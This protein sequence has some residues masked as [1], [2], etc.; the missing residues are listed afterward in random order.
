M[1]EGTSAVK[2]E[3]VL[4]PKF[5]SHGTLGSKDLEASRKFY[6]QFLGIEVIRTSKISMMIRLGGEHV[7]AVVEQKSR[8]EVM[9]RINHNGLDVGTDAEVDE[10]HRQCTEQAEKWGIHDITKPVVQHGTYSFM[11]W[12]L[13]DNCWEILSNPR[14]GYTWIFEQ[15][16]LSGKGHWEKDFRSKRPDMKSEK[17][18]S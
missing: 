11:F 1:A 16:D 14:G 10:A 13:D 8:K 5:I 18:A 4:K 17:P 9:Q 15:G 3:S 7:Y 6:E 2:P 12:D